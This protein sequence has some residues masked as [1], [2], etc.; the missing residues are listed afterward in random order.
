MSRV[1]STNKLALDWLYKSEQP[2]RSQVSKLTQLLTLTTTQKFSL[3]A[4]SMTGVFMLVNGGIIA[5]S[6]FLP[7]FSGQAVFAGLFGL[8]YGV[9]NSGIV[10][11]L[12]VNMY[13]LVHYNLFVIYII[14]QE[15]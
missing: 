7:S 3:Q 9:H 13:F 5:G 12:K 11:V 15:T 4:V 8:T 10:V 6:A 1:R 14:T 2:I